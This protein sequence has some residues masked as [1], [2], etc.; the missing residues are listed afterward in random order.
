[1]DL[2]TRK[3][4]YYGLLGLIIAGST[5]FA[6][7]VSPQVMRIQFLA[8][9]GTFSL[10]MNDIHPDIFPNPI[11]HESIFA[12]GAAQLPVRLPGAILSLNVTIDSV[13]LQV[14]GGSDSVTDITTSFT[15]DVMNHLNVLSLIAST[16]IPVE[17]VTMVSL[18]VSNAVASVAGVTGLLPVKVPSGELKVPVSPAVHVAAQTV[19]SV[20]LSGTAHIVFTGMGS[21][22]LTPE[23]H[24]EKTS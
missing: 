11:M 17:N 3:M 22:I 15:F 7:R 2:A 9:D 18:H 20:V 5:I 6:F 12:F 21:I 14:S 24:V 16:K 10:Y 23:L 19:S 4:V 8:K 1:M 13:S